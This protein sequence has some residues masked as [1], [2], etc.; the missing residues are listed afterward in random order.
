[1]VSGTYWNID[2]QGSRTIAYL[3]VRDSRNV[4]AAI[5]AAHATNNVDSGNNPGWNFH[6]PVANDVE[7]FTDEDTTVY[8]ALDTTDDDTGDSL[9]HAILTYGPDPAF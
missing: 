9:V 7:L 6:F 2:P 8:S 1:M 3:D 5:I 4:N